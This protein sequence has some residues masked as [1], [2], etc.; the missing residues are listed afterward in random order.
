MVYLVSMLRRAVLTL[1]FGA[2]IPIL[3]LSSMAVRS[4]SSER[5]EAQQKSDTQA[6]RAAEHVADQLQG[7]LEQVERSL[8]GHIRDAVRAGAVDPDEEDPPSSA[9]HAFNATG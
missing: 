5:G 2:G 7:Q 1:L 3:A 8:A 4:I 9:E 6:L